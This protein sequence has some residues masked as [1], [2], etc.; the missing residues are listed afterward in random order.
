MTSKRYQE[1]TDTDKLAAL[2]GRP[3][4]LGSGRHHYDR[5]V[6][7]AYGLL[8]TYPVREIFLRVLADE[9]QRRDPKRLYAAARAG[10]AG[11]MPGL[12]APHDDPTSPDLVIDNHGAC[13]AEHAVDMIWR[14]L[15]DD[16]A[17]KAAI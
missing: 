14:R 6:H 3:G 2:T 13:S 16:D 15:V 10:Q 12:D 7:F 17:L 5:L 4:L 9:R 1:Q 8:L 11:P